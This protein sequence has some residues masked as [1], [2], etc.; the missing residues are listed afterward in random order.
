MALKFFRRKFRGLGYTLR[1]C[2][3][4]PENR[5]KR[6]IP[7]HTA[8][9][10]PLQFFRL[11]YF[12]RSLSERFTQNRV[13]IL[14][15]KIVPFLRWTVVRTRAR[16]RQV[17]SAARKKMESFTGL[18]GVRG[19]RAEIHAFRVSRLVSAVRTVLKSKTSMDN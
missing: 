1:G 19:S 6:K 10:T 2:P 5:N 17:C 7:F 14:D 4:I 18:S 11:F 16:E 13:F 15:Y 9:P 12:A 8:F 3:N